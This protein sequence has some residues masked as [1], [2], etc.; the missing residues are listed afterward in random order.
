VALDD[1]GLEIFPTHRL[2]A[3]PVPELN[4]E[5]AQTPLAGSG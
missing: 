2:T 5:Y 3:G 4:G 1:P